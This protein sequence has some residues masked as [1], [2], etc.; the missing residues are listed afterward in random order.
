MGRESAEGARHAGGAGE[1]DAGG[2]DGEAGVDVGVPR[3]DERGLRVDHLDV[4]G[5]A[6]DE[7]FARL[8]ELLLG[9]LQAFVGEIGRA[10]CRERV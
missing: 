3:A 6:V 2:S 1:G 8:R 7:A 5:D 9:Q 10:S 4:A